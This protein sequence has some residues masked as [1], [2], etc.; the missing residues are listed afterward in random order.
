[1]LRA[2]FGKSIVMSMFSTYAAFDAKQS[3]LQ[4]IMKEQNDEMLNLDLR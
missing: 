4:R 3:E 2:V 1:M